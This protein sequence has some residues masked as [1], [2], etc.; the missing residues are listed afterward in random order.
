MNRDAP[1]DAVRPEQPRVLGADPDAPPDVRLSRSIPRRTLAIAAAAIVVIVASAIGVVHLVTAPP[2]ALAVFQNAATP[3]DLAATRALDG[4][5]VPYLGEPRVLAVE[6]DL[7]IVGSRAPAGTDERLALAFGYPARLGSTVGDEDGPVRSDSEICVWVIAADGA[8]RGRCAPPTAFASAGVGI[9]DVQV[10]NETIAFWFPDG[11]AGVET[12]A[13]GPTSLEQ[14]RALDVPALDELERSAETAD[15]RE[16]GVDYFPKGTLVLPAR[17]LATIG[18]W[19]LIASVIRPSP[20]SGL[21]VCVEASSDG[22]A[23]VVDEGCL[24]VATFV[25]T[26]SRGSVLVARAPDQPSTTIAWS[27]MPSGDIT[28]EVGGP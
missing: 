15:A 14:L 11:S 20:G 23:E 25:A 3:E 8:A 27:W 28:F 16:L 7:R 6:G 13:S 24:D 22:T 10:A 9:A 5:R 4:E 2:P 12:Y 18:D 1:A 17:Q 26:G 21:L 19:R